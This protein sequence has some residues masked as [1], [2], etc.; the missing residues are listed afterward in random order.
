MKY[1]YLSTVFLLIF[2]K[3]SG[4][5]KALPDPFSN[6][7]SPYGIMD[8]REL[9]VE[10]EVLYA[11]IN[12]AVCMSYNNGQNW[13]FAFGTSY[14]D[15]H[16]MSCTGSSIYIGNGGGIYRSNDYGATY[17]SIKNNLPE[18]N[19]V[20]ALLVTDSVLLVSVISY[21]SEFRNEVYF[22]FD[23]GDNWYKS[24][25]LSLKF[26][27]CFKVIENK[28]YAG[29]IYGVYLSENNG[30]SWSNI[31]LSD[32][33]INTI[34]G[35]DSI[36][37]AGG[38]N[39]NGRIY[40]TEDKGSNWKE[41]KNSSVSSLLVTDK[42]IYAA[43]GYAGAYCSSD[44]G[45]NWT[46]IIEENSSNSVNVISVKGNMILTGFLNGFAISTD[47]GATW[48]KERSGLNWSISSITKAGPYLIAASNNGLYTT[49]DNGLTWERNGIDLNIFETVNT[50]MY[51]GGKNG[52]FRSDYYGR[53]LIWHGI[54]GI[55][56]Y[57]RV[58]DIEAS[59]S[60]VFASLYNHGIYFSDDFGWNWSEKNNGIT[61]YKL[62]AITL[63][64]STVFAASENN[65]IY[66]S[67]DFGL[68]WSSINN[69]ILDTNITCLSHYRNNVYAG[70]N[71]KGIFKSN[72][73]GENWIQLQNEF[74]NSKILCLYT[75][76]VNIFAGV[77]GK[78]FFISPNNGT[79]WYSYNTGLYDYKIN[80]ITEDDSLVYLGTFGGAIWQR[81][82][83]ELPITLSVKSID[84][85]NTIVCEGQIVR[86][87]AHVIGGKLPYKYNWSDG[88]KTA[89]I[90]T[91]P[92]STTNYSF[93]VT[94]ANNATASY[95]VKI[96]VKPK[97]IT[98]IIKLIGDTLES[99]VAMGNIWLMN[100]K[101]INNETQSKLEIKKEGIY[102]LKVINEDCISDASNTVAIGNCWEL[103]F[104]NSWSIFSFPI[105]LEAMDMKSNFKSLI[106]SKSLVKIQDDDGNSLEDWGIF[107]GWTNGI[108]DINPGKGYKIKVTKSDSL[109][110]CGSLVE[111]PFSIHLKSGW[112][113]IGYPQLSAFD[114][115][116][117][118][119]KQLIDRGTFLKVQDE[120]GNSIENWGVFG[121]WT[122]NIGDFIPGKGYKI[123]V[124]A[125]DTLLI[126]DDYLKSKT[127]LHEIVPTTHFIPDYKGNGTDHMNINVVDLPINLL[128]AGD[129]LAIFDGTACVGAVKIMTPQLE[130]KRISIVASATDNEGMTG[131]NEGN[132]IILKL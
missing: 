59:G 11:I 60:A 45:K 2:F 39:S 81:P 108:G 54:N 104:S 73:N 61:S 68:N 69:G 132:P 89:S 72:D 53:N 76:G 10:K 66:R 37:V 65:G 121:G 71:S 27:K 8:F 124:S 31:G 21:H 22:S 18:F 25:G 112:N 6:S 98:P 28:I 16:K 130:S 129:E 48:K 44:R 93:T 47:N 26:V 50:V 24:E 114:G 46:K 97:P 92:L 116:N 107:G 41:I 15:A 30:R 36:I 33:G 105:Q 49:N 14:I 38:S 80:A 103:K 62:K 35:N 7:W 34:D 100:G 125:R 111:Y 17:H 64:D 88:S 94:D 4:Q 29:T 13:M 102:S 106:D 115:M 113:I 1:I 74:S 82:L 19:E 110:F 109:E 51:L 52:L 117:N 78:G 99:N 87:K 57:P 126:Y 55:P 101:V 123:K 131:F 77:E 84:V 5:W 63:V 128:K 23:K 43:A 122:N 70:S 118:I 96:W 58:T 120:N 119:V 20:S 90:N 12:N 40:L 86:L 95:N 127:I 85:S 56:E 42:Y 91:Y 3:T 9:V 67:T 75:Y 83:N 79:D 32:K